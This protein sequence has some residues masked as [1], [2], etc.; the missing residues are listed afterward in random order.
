[1][2]RLMYDVQP[3]ADLTR[4]VVGRR[5]QYVASHYTSRSEGIARVAIPFILTS[6]TQAI[7][8]DD[9]VHFLHFPCVIDI[10]GRSN[11]R[12]TFSIMG[13]FDYSAA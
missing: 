4:I 3:D 12:L 1:M 2:G 6:T 13:R 5:M 7:T 10:T 8:M 9:M 11:A